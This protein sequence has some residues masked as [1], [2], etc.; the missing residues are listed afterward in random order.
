[1]IEIN[2]SA[3]IATTETNLSFENLS[4]VDSPILAP[5]KHSNAPLS[6]ERPSGGFIFNK[7]VTDILKQIL[8]ALVQEAGLEMSRYSL[9]LIIYIFRNCQSHSVDEKYYRIPLVGQTFYKHV[10]Q[11]QTGRQFMMQC[12]WTIMDDILLLG[13]GFDLS[14]PFQVLERKLD[15]VCHKL[16]SRSIEGKKSRKFKKE[17]R[18][19]EKEVYDAI[20]SLKEIP[21]DL[22]GSFTEAKSDNIPLNPSQQISRMSPPPRRNSLQIATPEIKNSH[23]HVLPLQIRA[24]PLPI[25]NLTYGT[26]SPLEQAFTPLSKSPPS[27]PTLPKP[28]LTK[29]PHS[30]TSSKEDV[31]FLSF[32]SNEVFV[33]P[34]T[35]FVQTAT[36]PSHHNIC[37]TT[38]TA[39]YQ[40]PALSTNIT[41]STPLIPRHVFVAQAPISSVS[42]SFS[43]SLPLPP[44]DSNGHKLTADRVGP[45]IAPDSFMDVSL[46]DNSKPIQDIRGNREAEQQLIQ[47][48]SMNR[49]IWKQAE[50]NAKKERRTSSPVGPVVPVMPAKFEIP[51]LRPCSS[52]SDPTSPPRRS[53]NSSPPPWAEVKLRNTPNSSPTTSPKRFKEFEEPIVDTKNRE[54]ERYL[55]RKA[56][57]ARQIWIQ[58]ETMAAKRLKPNSAS[59][60]DEMQVNVRT[61]QPAEKPSRS[62]WNQSDT[63]TRVPEIIKGS[64]PLD[65]QSLFQDEKM[66]LGMSKTQKIVMNS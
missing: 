58:N 3:V 40:I 10:W 5:R 9:E 49:Q 28:T 37:S 13:I 36:S 57:N 32:E 56:A 7:Q 52:G 38:T 2:H 16:A 15:T 65:K 4:R 53:P 31:V 1:M 11:Y 26:S 22:N 18:F 23:L 6:P 63:K 33:T 20:P 44:D 41:T 60:T 55:E 64:D 34:D 27:P 8:E 61:P 21:A 19:F 59:P 66:L 54:A 14:K 45:V 48:V 29:S 47:Q 39:L 62:K 12:Q 51:K 43:D 42:T 17:V 24:S 50:Q 46:P 30:H 25:S 35:S